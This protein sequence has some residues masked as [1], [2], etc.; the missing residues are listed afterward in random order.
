MNEHYYVGL[1]IGSASIK[2]V[3]GEKFKDGVNIIGTGET[4]TDS[5]EKGAIVDFESAKTAIKDTLKKASIA[6][7]VNI[8]ELFVT[9]PYTLSESYEV[10]EML[11]FDGQ[12]TEL[13]GEHIEE[14]F[15]RV[16]EQVMGMDDVEVIGIEPLVFNVD[17]I[18]EVDDPKEIIATQ[19]VELKAR[20][21]GVKKS[22]LINL[23]KCVDQCDVEVLDVYSSAITLENI[24]TDA[25]KELGSLVIDI[26]RDITEL[27]YYQRGV[28]VASDVV[29]K[30]GQNITNDIM[31]AFEL[32]Y[33]EAERVK[34]QH[35][36]AFYPN[37]NDT[38]II[39][40]TDTN[41]DEV[42]FTE[43]DLSDV[44]EARTE[45]ILLEVLD[46]LQKHKIMHVNGGFVLTGGT[47]NVL[48]IKELMQ[49]IVSE[50]VRIHVPNHMGARKPQFS[51]VISL[52]SSSI[53]FDELLEYVKIEYHNDLE[54]GKEIVPANEEQ[55]TKKSGFFDSFKS[56][57]K[58]SNDIVEEQPQ[59]K[60]EQFSDEFVSTHRDEDIQRNVD[61][62]EQT[63]QTNDHSNNET[64]EQNDE[65]RKE[66]SKLQKFMKSLFE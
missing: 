49:D 3:V 53:Y 36:N 54:D 61:S 25:E 28:L 38:D 9:V 56:K 14:L 45:E 35:G 46:L 31:H 60:D 22:L 51:R 2:V 58:E 32:S 64:V 43:Q 27:N 26:G 11:Q 52:I 66:E 42:E 30:G 29:Y 7:G 15:D 1:D 17:D 13:K 40:S 5:I 37:A 4:Y 50:K 10:D 24:L 55:P 57:K 59:D 39:F 63:R 6:S 23:L 48:G 41:G 44:I 65:E 16:T 47:T 21:I 34:S 62:N 8:T 20:A 19:F 12:E 18:H 33:D